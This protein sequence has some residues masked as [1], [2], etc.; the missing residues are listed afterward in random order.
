MPEL[1]PDFRGEFSTWDDPQR[2]WTEAK[3][4]MHELL[5]GPVEISGI[6]MEITRPIHQSWSFGCDVALRSSSF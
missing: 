4:W 6:S 2:D 1:V 5:E 3:I